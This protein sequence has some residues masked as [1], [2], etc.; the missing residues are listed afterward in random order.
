MLQVRAGQPERL[1]EL[2]ARHHLK[3]FNFFRKLGN[4]RSGSEDLVQDTFLRMLKYA[5]SYQEARSFMPWMFQIAR[6]AAADAGRE[7]GCGRKQDGDHLE[8]LAADSHGDPEMLHAFADTEKKLQQALMRLPRDKREL[9]LLSRVQQLG[10][11]DLSKLFGCSSSAIKV[12][13]HRSLAL[14][15]EYFDDDQH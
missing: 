2:F 10:N 4:S 9:V 14:L 8:D 7:A 5:S 11:D 12:R 15:R 3:L 13:L 1:A 6:N